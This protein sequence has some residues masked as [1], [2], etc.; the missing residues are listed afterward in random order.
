[1]LDQIT[2][3][4][5][6]FPSEEFYCPPAEVIAYEAG[7]EHRG[8]INIIHIPTGFKLD[9]Y[10]AGRDPLHE[11]AL[12]EARELR[13]AGES[14]RVAPPEYVILRKLEFYRE[15]GSEKHL[16][17]IRMMLKMSGRQID[18]RQLEQLIAERG[19]RDVWAQIT[20]TQL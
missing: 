8:H 10:F 15:G 19:L 20:N 7:R 17:D 13:I 9:L 14:V 11:W 2:D 18:V 1:M 5:K 6:A 12:R 4:V 3:L 16:R